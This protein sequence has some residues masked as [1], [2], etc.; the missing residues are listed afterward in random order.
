MKID[1]VIPYVNKDDPNWLKSYTNTFSTPI[2]DY[3]YSSNDT[4]FKF[5]FR[6]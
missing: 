3:R 4:L 5:F 6:G 1:L 2:E